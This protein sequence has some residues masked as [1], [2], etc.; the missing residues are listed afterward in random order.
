MVD[1]GEGEGE[2]DA[3]PERERLVR[4]WIIRSDRRGQIAE[5]ECDN[6]SIGGECAENESADHAGRESGGQER[7]VQR[8]K[9]EA[10]QSSDDEDQE[11]NFRV[12]QARAAAARL[13]TAAALRFKRES[14]GWKTVGKEIHE[15]NLQGGERHGESGRERSADQEEFVQRVRQ[16][17]DDDLAHV[18]EDAPALLDRDHDSFQVVV[19]D[20][21]IGRAFG[22]VRA[23]AHGYADSG[24]MERR[25]V[26]HSV[27]RDRHHVAA[28]L[29][30]PRD[31]DFLFRCHAGEDAHARQP[32]QDIVGGKRRELGAGDD[33]T[34]AIG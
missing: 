16:E 10:S 8:K 13:K 4:K 26:V 23:G 22:H 31:H 21:Q 34:R 11:A 5:R 6:Q 18:I 28:R 15:Q 1:G 12:E 3:H 2:A 25:G 17:I 32:A 19:Q 14:D 29:K 9:E 7:P 24:A 20:H 27:A 33:G 30:E